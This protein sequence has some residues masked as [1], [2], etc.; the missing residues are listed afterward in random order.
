MDWLIAGA[1]ASALTFS[2][3]AAIHACLLAWRGPAAGETDIYAVTGILSTA[4]VIAVPLINWSKTLRHL[5]QPKESKSRRTDNESK[6]T[7]GESKQ[8]EGNTRTIIIYWGFLVAVGFFCAFVL[9]YSP[10][11]LPYVDSDND[12][13]GLDTLQCSPN[14]NS[15]N[16]SAGQQSSWTTFWIT[17]EFIN[18]NNCV[19]PC[20]ISQPP[21]FGGALFRHPT[22]LVSMTSEQV[23]NNIE[24]TNLSQRRA[25]A[26]KFLSFY[27]KY[28]LYALPY[29]VAQG[30]TAAVFGRKSPSKIRWVVYNFIVSIGENEAGK[31]QRGFATTIALLNYLWALLM[32]I[33]CPPTFV[34]NIIATEIALNPIP[35]GEYLTA[36]GQ[37]QPWAG[38][39]LILIAAL[40]AKTEKDL[41]D[42]F[43]GTLE[44]IRS[45]FGRMRQAYEKSDDH[46]AEGQGKPRSVLA[47]FLRKQ[48][49]APNPHLRSGFFKDVKAVLK[50]A[51]AEFVWYFRNGGDIFQH[52]WNI[53]WDFVHDPGTKP[54]KRVKLEEPELVLPSTRDKNNP[55][56]VRTFFKQE[57]VSVARYIVGSGTQSQKRAATHSGYIGVGAAHTNT[58]GSDNS[59]L[60]HSPATTGGASHPEVTGLPSPQQHSG[61][62]NA[63]LNQS[64][65]RKPLRS[66]TAPLAAGNMASSFNSPDSRRRRRSQAYAHDELS[67]SA[68]SPGTQAPTAAAAEASHAV[69]SPASSSATEGGGRGAVRNMQIRSPPDF[70]FESGERFQIR[71]GEGGEWEVVPAVESGDR[72]GEGGVEESEGLGNVSGNGNPRPMG[73]R[74]T[75][76]S[77][78][79]G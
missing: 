52:E 77:Q 59:T 57:A 26:R 41:K 45:K 28:A 19:E 60:L 66:L 73:R 3:S 72:R 62:A 53:F 8:S 11:Y 37:W 25:A 67:P 46:D 51:G 40:I 4:C 44:N 75:S 47:E 35:Q 68:V 38:T 49:H 16:P 61:I 74:K 34:L 54:K 21:L 7:D 33:A 76:M 5:G 50:Y 36:I 58:F 27:E 20:A 18:E 55:K 42:R 31:F 39:A 70:D 71:R 22:D 78:S 15:L 17:T 64:I 69:N 1:L 32:L 48:S 2:G 10:N 30:I 13:S 43:V 6:Q 14:N 12:I 56:S 63:T 65:N 79:Q 9:L 24:Q 23:N 29:I